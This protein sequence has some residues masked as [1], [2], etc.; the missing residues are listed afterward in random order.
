MARKNKKPHTKNEGGS[1]G[2]SA[3]ETKQTRGNVPLG[4]GKSAQRR[5]W[6]MQE[7]KR[8]ESRKPKEWTNYP[9]GKKRDPTLPSAHFK[10][11]NL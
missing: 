11:H 3:K 2:P 4:K 5:E 8:K 1:F 7:K 9:K 10:K 6:W